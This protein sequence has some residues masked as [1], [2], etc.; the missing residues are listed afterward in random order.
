MSL[1]LV[2]RSGQKLTPLQTDAGSLGSMRICWSWSPV[3]MMTALLLLTGCAVLPISDD[4]G[5]SFDANALEP[6]LGATKEE[7]V[8][9]LGVPNFHLAGEEKSYFLY[10]E[11]S[12][13][14]EVVLVGL[15][16]LMI[17][18]EPANSTHSTGLALHCAI[19]EFNKDNFLEHFDIRVDSQWFFETASNL[20]CKSRFFAPPELAS[21]RQQ[22]RVE[23][24]RK[25]DEVRLRPEAAQGDPDAQYRLALVVQSDSPEQW[26]LYCQ[27]A[28]QGHGKAQFAIAQNFEHGWG[29]VSRDRIMAY[30]WYGAAEKKWICATKVFR[31][32]YPNR[33]GLVVLPCT[34]V[35]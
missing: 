3:Y 26:R 35:S 29:P 25:F 28:A 12:E 33:S 30:L 32:L 8:E 22:D 11:I 21:L 19:L 15:I 27:A 9:R 20:D 5:K 31:R 7:L 10:Q 14:A 23:L 1:Q 2:E 6:L 13:Q 34:N 18:P 24:T 16:P 4:V 17:E